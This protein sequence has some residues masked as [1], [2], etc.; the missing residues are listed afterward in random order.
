MAESEGSPCNP[1]V[2]AA[3]NNNSNSSSQGNNNSQQS[4]QT[5]QTPADITSS[6]LAS[7]PITG[8]G[9]FLLKK[10]IGIYKQIVLINFLIAKKRNFYL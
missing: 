4:S 3:A 6:Q 1:V 10:S 5:Q 9:T 7:P 2:V 8:T